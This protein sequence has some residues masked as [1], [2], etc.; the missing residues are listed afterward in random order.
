MSFWGG[1]VTG[2]AKTAKDIIDKDVERTNELVDDTVKIGVNKYLE[3]EE[4][5]KAEKKTIRDELDTLRALKFSLPKAASI[6]RAGQTANVIKL[7]NKYTGADPNDL[8]DGTTKFAEEKG[9]TVNDI[10]DKLVK[11][12]KFDAGNLKVQQPEG[13]LLSAL[14]LGT[15]MSKDIKEGIATRVGGTGTTTTTRDD[16]AIMPGGLTATGKGLISTSSDNIDQTIL[17]LSKKK[18]AGTITPGEETLLKEITDLKYGK[19]ALDKINVSPFFGGGA[20][21]TSIPIDMNLLNRLHKKA[22]SNDPDAKDAQQKIDKIIDQ[23]KNQ[24][25]G[26][27]LAQAI[28]DTLKNTK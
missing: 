28:V 14:G 13:S 25:G 2:F 20:K 16:I 3:N 9:L 18:I 23:I 8:W 7:T 6:I 24:P 17:K 10:L 19:T 15:D 21:Q 22:I 1:F 12:P 26:K 27:N 5:I 11:T 4:E